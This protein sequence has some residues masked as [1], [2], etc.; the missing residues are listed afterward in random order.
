MI[1]YDFAKLGEYA[2]PGTQQNVI[3][4]LQNN[5]GSRVK[6]AKEAGVSERTVRRTLKTVERAAASRGYSPDNDMTHT[7]AEGYHVKGTTTLYDDEG[8]PKLQWVKTDQDKQERSQA[9]VEAIKATFEDTPRVKPIKLSKPLSGRSNDLLCTAYCMGDP[10][11]GLYGWGLETLSEDNDLSTSTADLL[12]AVRQL[13][14]SSPP[15]DLGLIVNVGDFFHSD[16]SENRSQHSGHS[17][18]VDTRWAKVLDAGVKVMRECVEAALLKHKRVRVIN[19]VGNHDDHTSRILTVALAGIYENNPRVEFDLSPARFLYY[20][21]GKCLIGVNH[22]DKVKPDALG[23]IL[24]SD[25]PREWGDSLYRYWYTG[26]IHNKAV[27]ELKGCLVESFRTLSGKDAWTAHMGYR[28]GRDM[29]AIVLH[30]E[31]GEVGRN[32]CDIRM[33]RGK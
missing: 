15:S 30:K 13:V 23:P 4:A 17:Y 20:Q 21:F 25:M 10:H 19:C 1:Y 16:S 6:A 31:Y 3:A 12:A 29:Q 7:T 27:W 14:S 22:G 11:I 33:I 8:K 5:N 28:S 32:R 2:T 26:H 9:L 18:D 24:A